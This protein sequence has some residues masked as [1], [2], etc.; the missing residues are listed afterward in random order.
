MGMSKPVLFL[1]AVFVVGIGGDQGTQN[2]C[3]NIRKRKT[4]RSASDSLA[5]S[6][7]LIAPDMYAPKHPHG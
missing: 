3:A 1:A 2:K 7:T 4:S 5:A 6:G